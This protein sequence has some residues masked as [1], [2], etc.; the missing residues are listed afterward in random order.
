MYNGFGRA[1][2]VYMFIRP[3]LMTFSV[4]TMTFSVYTMTFICLYAH[5]GKGSIQGVAFQSIYS[6]SL[7]GL[8]IYECTIYMYDHITLIN[9][10]I[11]KLSNNLYEKVV[12]ILLVN[13]QNKLE[14]AK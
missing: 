3:C 8:S 13:I 10:M 9:D 7:I 12:G 1:R 5:N 6:T 14:N 11:Y 2:D 4:Y